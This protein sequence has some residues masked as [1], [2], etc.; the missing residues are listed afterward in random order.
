ME[1]G[2]VMAEHDAPWVNPYP[3]ASEGNPYWHVDL[4]H[5]DGSHEQVPIQNIQAAEI[6]RRAAFDK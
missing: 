2:A 4:E 3:H 1:G 5:P 6:I